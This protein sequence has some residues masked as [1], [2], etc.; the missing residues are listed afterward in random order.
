MQMR[1]KISGAQPN[2]ATVRCPEWKA[3]NK[4]HEYHPDRASKNAVG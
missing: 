2:A 4:H 3:I 1:E